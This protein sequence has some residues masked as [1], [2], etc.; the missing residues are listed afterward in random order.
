LFRRCVQ[1]MLPFLL[2]LGAPPEGARVV[3]VSSVAG[4]SPSP[5]MSSYTASKHA[6]TA[7]SHSLRMEMI[8]WGLRVTVVEPGA[9]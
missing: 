9:G 5:L 6:I 7:F 4:F 1:E 3:N 8:E 2:R